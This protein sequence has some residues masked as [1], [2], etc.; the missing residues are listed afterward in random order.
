ME[1]II[2]IIAIVFWG[3]LILS[4]LVYI[5]E[6]GHFIAARIMGLRVKEFF[7][8]LP[9]RARL[10]RVSKRTGTAYGIT[11]VLM[12]GYTLICG[13]DGSK[14]ECL[15]RVLSYVYKQGSTTV[16]SAAIDLRLDETEVESALLTLVD[17]GSI[18]ETNGGFQ[19][20]ARDACM[21]TIYDKGHD[22]SESGSTKAGEPHPFRGTQKAFLEQ[23]RSH[24]YQKLGFWGRS[25]V[26]IN[27]ILINIV[28]G[29]LILVLTLSCLG[30]AVPSNSPTIGSVDEGSLAASVGLQAGDEI[31]AINNQGVSTWNDMAT[32]IA[33]A[34]QT[35]DP[36]T[37]TISSFSPSNDDSQA[38]RDTDETTST[39]TITIEPKIAG[40]KLGIRAATTQVNLSLPDACVAAASYI[41]MTAVAI[42]QLFNPTHFQE[43]ISQ[44]SSVVG[45]SVMAAD[46]AREG[47]TPLLMLTAAISL[48]LGF[49]NLLPIP[50]L[51]G[52]KIFIEAISAIIRRPVPIKVQ[53][54]ISYVGVLLFI[55][56]FIVLLKQDIVRY[57]LG[58]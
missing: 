18:E 50:P 25:F 52:G 26:L 54:I 6:A 29:F 27:G 15:A 37:V 48:S 8:G 45:I 30:V 9:C 49:M 5:H 31:V 24:T 23:E 1:Q 17:W 53:R 58:G 38:S 14:P 55:L 35:T 57:I 44:S 36:Y 47:I 40:E 28:A 43:V 21:R 3:L 34:S 7:I 41:G 2:R 4:A 10:A 20:L 22:F 19:T 13:M 33:A 51:D 32:A 56:L 16:S 12:G 11:P 46:A 42:A 39:R